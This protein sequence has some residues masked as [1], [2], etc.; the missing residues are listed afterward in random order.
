[1]NVHEDFTRR[2]KLEDVGRWFVTDFIKRVAREL[3]PGSR[4][5]DAG[6]GECVYQPFF[7]HCRYESVDLGVGEAA[8]NYENLDHVA[9]L[10]ELPMEDETYDAVLCTQVLEHLE[11]PRE[12]V[13]EFHRVLK[14]GG[15]LYLTAPMAHVEHQ[16]PYD[17]FRYTSFG[18]RSLLSGAG[19]QEIAVEPFGGMFTRWAYEMP[20]ALSIFPPLRW[21]EGG[22]RMK[23]A[24]L[25][26]LKVS[27]YVVLRAA[28]R[29]FL[30]LERLDKSKN[31]P[32][33]WWAI[34]VKK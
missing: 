4:L 13:T 16:T 14:K 31:D 26:P 29:G 1:M 27:C 24:L 32:F 23:G 34:A 21:P 11:R 18:L 6:A 5:L 12:S 2:S 22:I 25:L 17:F 33:G 8:W 10:D 7:A 15:R 28:Q 20:R 3:P 19:F 30:F 9:P